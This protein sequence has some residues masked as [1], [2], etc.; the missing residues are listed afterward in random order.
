MFLALITYAQQKEVYVFKIVEEIDAPAWRKTKKAIDEAENNNADLIVIRM[1]TYGGSVLYA[2]S[3][4]DKIFRSKLPVYVLIEN[5]AASAGA[6]ISMA[7]DSIYMQTGSTIGAATVV[8][9]AGEPMPDK[10]QS[11]MR[12]KMR[13]KAEANGRNPEIAEA[14]VDPSVIVPG[15][16]D[17]GKVVTFTTLEAM[18]YGFCEGEANSVAEVLEIVG[19]KDYNL[20]E[21]QLSEMD[22]ILDFLMSSGVSGFLIMI[23]IGGIYFELQSPG[24][25]FPILAS[26]V[27]ALLYFAPNYLEGMAENWEILLFVAGLIL[28]A[29]EVFVIPGFGIAGILGALFVVSGLTLSLVGNVGFEFTPANG[30]ELARALFTVIISTLLAIVVSIYLGSKLLSSTMFSRF[31]LET[32]QNKED[33][34]IGVDATEFDL[35]NKEGVTSTILRP[36]GKVEIEGIIYDATA[37]VG[38]IEQG[39]K[40]KVIRFETAQLF[41]RK[42]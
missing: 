31:V 14:M 22:S 35:L 21:Q 34:F 11:Y 2:D 27:A 39:E 20:A 29:L 41:V 8:N 4:S 32:S 12:K 6:F 5:N 26:L 25:G 30:D 40:I 33:G 19:I 1:N 7:C 18:K 3:I 38:Y 37:E 15:V 23:I 24:I 13:A 9:Q 42:I 36:V 16:S 17:S 28:L 10:Y